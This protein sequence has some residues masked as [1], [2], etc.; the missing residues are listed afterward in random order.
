LVAGDFLF[1][2]AGS[3]DLYDFLLVFQMKILTTLTIAG[4][5]IIA[6]IGAELWFYRYSCKSQA[7][8]MD[9]PYSWG[10][11]QGCMIRSKGKWV[12]LKNYRM[13]GVD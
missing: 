2:F 12:P 9:M 4:L 10:I 13:L 8:L 11:V 7:A 3:W 6:I 1:I 5:F